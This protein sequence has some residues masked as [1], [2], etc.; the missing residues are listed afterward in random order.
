M[1]KI[2]S[3]VLMVAMLFSLSAFAEEEEFTLHNG[4][5]FGMTME[6]VIEIE[7]NNGFVLSPG[8]SG[9]TCSGNGII[10][11][12]Q[13]T[14]I[15]YQ[16]DENDS[17]WHMQYSF[18]SL[19]TFDVVEQGLIKKYGN[20]DFS[21]ETGLAFPN[22]CNENPSF[23][24]PMAGYCDS[25]GKGAVTFDARLLNYSHRLVELDDGDCLFIEHYV[26]VRDCFVYGEISS[27]IEWHHL[28]YRLLTSDEI[29]T[30]KNVTAGSDDL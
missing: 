9:N 19:D 30:I 23:P 7:G 18:S 14:T 12:Q 5:T 26:W 11:N 13:G 24:V 8:E 1:K 2:I 3:L 21:S 17:L 22:I 10:A 28:K 4:T 20:T 6:E 15:S 29:A 27:V 25:T 16:F